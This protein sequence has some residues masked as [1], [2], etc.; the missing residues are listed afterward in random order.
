[1]VRQGERGAQS[2]QQSWVFEQFLLF[3]PQAP[4]RLGRDSE[5]SAEQCSPIFEAK[6][7]TYVLLCT[8]IT[9]FYA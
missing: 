9:L 2:W 4:H 3:D 7:N 1:M 8:R 6:N 5:S